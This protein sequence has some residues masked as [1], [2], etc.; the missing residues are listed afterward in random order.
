MSIPE[1]QKSILSGLAIP[2]ISPLNPFR[3]Q[4][5]AFEGHVDVLS[6]RPIGGAGRA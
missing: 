1:D 6:D 3:K 5:P 2:E 4:T